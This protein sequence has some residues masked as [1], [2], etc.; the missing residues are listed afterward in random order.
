MRAGAMS[1]GG[2]IVTSSWA[3]NSAARTRGGSAGRSC[4]RCIASPGCGSGKPQSQ[5][6]ARRSACEAKRWIAATVIHARRG[7]EQEDQQPVVG[8]A[9]RR[10]RNDGQPRQ[11][12]LR[13]QAR[14]DQRLRD[15]RQRVDHRAGKNPGEQAQCGESR[16]G[17]DG[18]SRRPRAPAAAAALRGRPR[19]TMPNALTKQAAASAAASASSAPSAGS[20]R[21]SSPIAA[22]RDAAGS[23]GRSAIRRRN[24]SAAAARRSP[25]SRPGTRSA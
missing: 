7:D 21:P 14:A 1:P 6:G 9:R 19:K 23:P 8:A 11:R 5:A 13:R 17:G 12:K 18:R 16:H 25:R 10:D 15:R 20:M 4:R 24:R 2:G 22:G 3:P